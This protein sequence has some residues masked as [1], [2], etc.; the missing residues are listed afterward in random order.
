[1]KK[2]YATYLS[3]HELEAQY[4]RLTLK[5]DFIFGKVMQ[6]PRIFKVHRNW[7][8]LWWLYRRAGTFI[9]ESPL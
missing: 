7:W 6:E 8:D 1:M 3:P 9:I 5:D 2:D 4:E